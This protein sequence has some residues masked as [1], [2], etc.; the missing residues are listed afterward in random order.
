[1]DKFVIGPENVR[2]GVIWYS[3]R[4]S[5]AFH[6]NEYDNADD[7]LDAIGK[8][9]YKDQETNTSGALRA[10]YT[11]MFSDVNGDRPGAQNI[12]IVVTDGASNRDEDLTIPE[13]NAARAAG[14]TVFAI[15]IGDEVDP[16]ELRGIAN[17]P[18]EQF[19]FNATDFD[20]LQH[21]RDIVSTAA[22]NAAAGKQVLLL[23]TCQKLLSYKY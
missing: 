3:N 19:T 12:G 10:M 22:C 8:I 2:V 4:A 16:H 5:I 17:E 23:S 20:A 21:I 7:V 13:A 9:P 6:L 15:G 14:V 1:M 11:L 18:S